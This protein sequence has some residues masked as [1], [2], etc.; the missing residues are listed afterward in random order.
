MSQTMDGELAITG[1]G[2]ISGFGVGTAAFERG[3]VEGR[4]AIAPVTAFDT[5][6][7]GSHQAGHVA[8]FDPSAFLHPAK[9]RRIDRVGRLAIAACRLALED[10]ALTPPTEFSGQDQ[11]GVAMGSAT[12]GLH[13]L[14]DYLDRLVAQGAAG[15]SALDFSNTVGNAA[16]SLCAIEFGLRGPNVTLSCREASGLSAVNQAA[17]ILRTN[18]SRAVVTGAVDDFEALFYGV[19]DQ[20]GALAVDEGS[21]EASRPFDRRRNGFVLGN[22]AFLL[23]LERLAGARDTHRL[24]SIAGTGATASRC[25]TNAWPDDPAQLV[26]CMRQ[27]LDAASVEPRDVAAVFAAANSTRQLDRVEAQ[28]LST[29]FGP[30]GVPVVALKGA[31]GECSASGAA[32]LVAALLA[33]KKRVIPPTVGFEQ[34]DPECPVDVANAARPL[35]RPEAR[36]ALVNAFASGGANHSVV[37]LA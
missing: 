22:G 4:S 21:G 17:N 1:I 31:L 15:A 5:S 30:F 34:P 20:F 37:V 18:R 28:A 26:R 2:C 3:L 32:G 24:G 13:S 29:V 10:A 19:H 27:A 9:L 36:A 11:I 33:L 7:A 23:V 8:D 14:V 25:R 12:A 16:A 35:V 6:R